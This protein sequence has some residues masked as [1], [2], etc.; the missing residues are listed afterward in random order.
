MHN[1]IVKNLVALLGSPTLSLEGK[2]PPRYYNNNCKEGSKGFQLIS[3]SP[4]LTGYERIKAF[5]KKASNPFR[6][7]ESGQDFVLDS[8]WK[9]FV[10]TE[11]V[12]RVRRDPP[13]TSSSEID[14]DSDV[15]VDRST[16]LGW[17]GN[18]LARIVLQLASPPSWPLQ[19]K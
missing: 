18:P 5:P 7:S 8:E 12:C 4:N 17:G 9:I 15:I 11:P 19:E 3:Q 6:S 13:I 16:G 10:L 1:A 14:F 2:H